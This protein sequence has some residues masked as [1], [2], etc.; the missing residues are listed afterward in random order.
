MR[1]TVAVLLLLVVAAL[2]GA[3]G[4]DAGKYG[5]R[6]ASTYTIPGDSV[7]PEGVGYDGRKSLYVS[8]TG[9][10]TIFRGTIGRRTLTP[11]LP[12]GGD[13]RTTA[14]GVKATR[15]RIYVAGGATGL[16]WIYDAHSGA[17]VRRFDT[18]AGGFLN[19]LAVTR[20]GKVYVTDSMRPYVFRVDG[21]NVEQFLTLGPDAGYDGGMGFK[22]NG[23]AATRDGRTLIAVHST[24]GALY[25]VDVAARR[26]TK[27][28]TGAA[29]LKN[30]DGIV[31][32]GSTLYVV[33]NQNELIVK[34]ELNRSLTRARQVRSLTDPS[35]MYPTTVALAKGRLIVVNSQFDRRS[36]GQPPELPFTLSSIKR[37]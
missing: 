36:A 4:A 27:I 35:F 25:R 20:D 31:L 12:A 26:V 1:R 37:P 32:E 33:R 17:L 23:I 2:A 9:D 8:S 29:D 16:I 13:G 14:V 3:V 21:P 7:F 15:D 30:G 34:L 5:Q 11:F 6:P 18:G 28:D 24:N 22:W 19:D 10:G